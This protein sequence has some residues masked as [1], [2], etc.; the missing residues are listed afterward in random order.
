MLFLVF[1]GL[2]SGWLWGLNF[3]G[4]GMD[5]GS[6]LASKIDEKSDRFRDRFLNGLKSGLRSLGERSRSSDPSPKDTINGVLLD[7]RTGVQYPKGTVT[8]DWGLVPG[9]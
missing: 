9:L 3:C 5:F 1:L 6:I 7:S 4:F 2:V 8:R